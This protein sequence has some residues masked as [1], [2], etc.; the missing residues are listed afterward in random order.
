MNIVSLTFGFSLLAQVPA[1]TEAEAKLILYPY[2]TR[3]AAAYE[4]Y[5][6][7]GRTQR[8]ALREQPVLTW[9]NAADG[10]LGG[11]FVWTYGG[12]PEV[13]GCIGSRQTAVGECIVFHE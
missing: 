2:Y 12:R 8:L 6:D 4:F 3:Q 11:V 10:Y 13:L 9:T 1:M 5:L 7:E